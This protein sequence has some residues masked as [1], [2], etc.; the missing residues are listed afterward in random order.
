[1]MKNAALIGLFTLLAVAGTVRIDLV[2]Q[3]PAKAE[4]QVPSVR[5]GVDYLIV[6]IQTEVQRLLLVRRQDAK[7]FV[8]LNGAG[9]RDEDGADQ[10]LLE[11]VRRDLGRTAAKGDAVL[12]SIF[13]GDSPERFDPVRLKETL[14][15]IAADLGLKADPSEVE[16]RNDNDTWQERVATMEEGLPAQPAGE[17]AGIGDRSVKAYPVRTLLSR[18]LTG[19][20]DCV[21]DILEPLAG[22]GDE[23]TFGMIRSGVSELELVRK[24]Q[25]NFRIHTPPDG[26]NNAARDQIRAELIRLS[27]SLGFKGYSYSYIPRPRLIP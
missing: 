10:A 19:G 18:Y 15:G 7:F 27:K 16:W 8:A 1:M 6:P 3:E 20:G 22:D 11:A 14:A 12:F 17:E 4:P 21:V 13:F 9:L 2:A 23:E 25:I 5:R 26:V 24:K